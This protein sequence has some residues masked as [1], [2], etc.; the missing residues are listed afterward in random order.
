MEIEGLFL[1]G[2]LLCGHVSQS[3]AANCDGIPTIILDPAYFILSPS[4]GVDDD[5]V[6]ELRNARQKRETQYH[7]FIC[8][9][10]MKQC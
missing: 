4:Y 10:Q 8:S 3:C 1:E 9:K 6:E 5:V 2:G 7:M